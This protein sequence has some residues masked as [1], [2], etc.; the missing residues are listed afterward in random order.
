[1]TPAGLRNLFYFL[2]WLDPACGWFPWFEHNQGALSVLALALAGGALRWEYRQARKAEAE[3][4]AAREAASTAAMQAKTEAEARDRRAT[5]MAKRRER[6]SR[7]IAEQ[8]E[9][10]FYCLA[11]EQLLSSLQAAAQAEI[12]RLEEVSP[13]EFPDMREFISEGRRVERAIEALLARPPP[14]PGAIL[15]TC[16]G[17]E[18]FGQWKYLDVLVDPKLAIETVRRHMAV[19]ADAE[20]KLV[21][22]RDDAVVQTRGRLSDLRADR[23]IAGYRD[24]PVEP[25]STHPAPQESEKPAAP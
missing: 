8:N 5:F 14:N 3:A 4:V 22:A 18:P 6:E 1:M 9:L 13:G 17:L 16:R 20:G 12:R 19:V 24:H 2:Q 25:G 10:A 7:I 21:K 15:A 23:E 11:V